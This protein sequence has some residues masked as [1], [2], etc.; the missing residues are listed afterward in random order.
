MAQ[1]KVI[2][3][4]KFIPPLNSGGL[5]RLPLCIHRQ[6]KH[7]RDACQQFDLFYVLK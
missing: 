6:F 2:F 3:R 4:N 1:L 5:D 7:K